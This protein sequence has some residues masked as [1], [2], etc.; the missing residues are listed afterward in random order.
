MA[1]VT[2][3]GLILLT[4]EK[5]SAE[6]PFLVLVIRF[7]LRRWR[8][9]ASGYVCRRR[10]KSLGEVARF[11]DFAACESW[12]STAAIG[13]SRLP[14]YV[15]AFDVG[16][17]AYQLPVEYA[18]R[19]HNSLWIATDVAQEVRFPLCSAACCPFLRVH[20]IFR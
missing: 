4:D 15:Q 2:V 8:N 3:S 9:I 1:I 19:L 16:V 13:G 12:K 20:H 6:M 7:L 14:K 10:N 5:A 18:A 11:P 17:C